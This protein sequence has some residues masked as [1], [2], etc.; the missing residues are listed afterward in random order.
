MTHNRY[1]IYN[2]SAGSGKTYT[3]VRDYLSI[4]LSH[5]DRYYFKHVIAIT[6]TN[7]AA[8][9]M[10]ER[11]T[12]NLSCIS[13]GKPT[14]MSQELLAISGLDQDT[15]QQRASNILQA[16][17]ADYSSFNITTIDA[18]THKI[19]RSFAHEF[20]LSADFDIELNTEK[21]L[22]EAIDVVLSRLGEDETLTKLLVQLSIERSDE[23]KSWD[24]R[25][26]LYDFSKLLLNEFDKKHF[27]S[28][29]HIKRDDLQGIAKEFYKKRNLLKQQLAALG[30]NALDI[31]STHE[32]SKG[33]FSRNTFPNH[34]KK[35]IDKPED[36]DYTDGSTVNRQINEDRLINKSAKA[37]IKAT[38]ESVLPQLLDIYEQ[39]RKHHQHYILYQ[40]FTEG[41]QPMALL[42]DI[43]Q[44]MQDLKSQKN[45]LFISDFNELI[46]E[47]IKDEPIPFIYERI[48]ERYKHF[49]ID[50]MQDTS[51]L[52]WQNLVPLI[53][54]EL[55]N[56]GSLLL[57]GD[58]KQSIYRWR[59]SVPEQFIALAESDNSA[60]FNTPKTVKNLDTNFR[61]FSEIIDFNNAFYEIIA[62]LFSDS[63]YRSLY[64]TTS[65]QKQNTKQG[66]YVQ[67]DFVEQEEE[68]EKTEVI[69][70]R[71]LE[72][73][74][75]IDT[76]FSPSDICILVR[77]RNQSVII[78]DFLMAHGINVQSGESLLL[79]SNTSVNFLINSLKLCQNPTD[80]E[81]RVKVLYDLYHRFD[82]QVD[83]HEFISKGIKTTIQA[84]ESL[85]NDNGIEFYLSTFN[86]K[87]L[88]AGTEYLIRTLLQPRSSDVYLMTFL[89]YVLSYQTTNGSNL[90]GFL[91][92]WEEQKD[93]LSVN[94]SNRENAVQILT[95][96]KAKGLQ[97][98]VVILPYDLKIDAYKDAKIWYD[99]DPEEQ[100][101]LLSKI[102]I[103]VKKKLTNATAKA[104]A[105]YEDFMSK[106]QLDNIN[107]LYVG[108][109]RAVEQLYIITSPGTDKNGTPKTNYF[110]GL[111]THFLQLKDVWSDTQ[112]TYSFGDKKRIKQTRSGSGCMTSTAENLTLDEFISHDISNTKIRIATTASELWDTP[113]GKAINY[114]NLIHKMMA[115]IH[116]ED[117]I[118][119]TVF[120]FQ[121]MG[122]IKADEVALYQKI[123]TRIVKHPDLAHCFNPNYKVMT[124]RE[125]YNPDTHESIIP[126]RL[127]FF[128]TQHIGIYDYKTGTP[129]ETHQH[130]LSHY[131]HIL[132]A[133]GYKVKETCLIYIGTDSV[134]VNKSNAT[135]L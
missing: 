100:P 131:A 80:D 15:F 89:D 52:Q 34:F 27:D 105:L 24:I 19:I 3:L 59:G 2:A 57:V 81:L 16:I 68:Q 14:D 43:Y 10:K 129:L 13:H 128:D 110:S 116:S 114:G 67:I 98:P 26:L 135:S 102:I 20:G 25:H 23:D 113:Q 60:P 1:T 49:F 88:Y 101:G 124:E 29:S 39:A 115:D 48:G 119:M 50:E 104:V 112:N 6:F 72:T 51:V 120:N 106:N 31:I 64:E 99:F 45:I 63:L 32:L 17:F 107:L 35:L 54:N 58:G 109:T 85:L 95:Y 66:G 8:A 123:L 42:I 55:D 125:I 94:I 61:S 121:A 86:Q 71:V 40:L 56:E 9:E 4:L 108:T 65:F 90:S 30:Q 73:I 87:T 79:S 11:I 103:P 93:K 133:M 38:A 75:N 62:P 126:D 47:M 96:H 117:D 82:P 46:Y 41:L 132:T 74:E 91:E 12:S 5:Q 53:K 127:V 36:V 92:L 78:A 130:Q 37:D 28:I 77:T 21:I 18:L 111:F 97:F 83:L 134:E 7:K 44:A 84:F 33:C 76:G 118:D 69:P 70:Q 22:Q 122:L